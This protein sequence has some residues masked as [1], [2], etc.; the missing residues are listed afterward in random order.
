M[1][2]EN[3]NIELIKILKENFKNPFIALSAE[4]N[5]ITYNR[6]AANFFTIKEEDTNIFDFL[7]EDTSFELSSIMEEVLAGGKT[8]TKNII[9][10]LKNGKHAKTQVTISEF[11]QSFIFVTLKPEEHQLAINEI[12]KLK[13]KREEFS[14]LI[15]NQEI[16]KLI[17]TIKDLY[18]FTVLG[19]EKIR[20]E[21][22][23]LEEFLW[24]KNDEG[25]F[26]L[27]NNSL[28][29]NLGLRSVQ[30]EGK[31]E[32]ELLPEYLRE[33]YTS[34][35]NYIKKSHN[36]IVFEGIPGQGL[37]GAAGYQTIEIPLIDSEGN[38]SAII[39]IGQKTET[40]VLKH[41]IEGQNLLENLPISLATLNNEG[42]IKHSSKEFCKLF[43]DEF[44]DF[45]NLSYTNVF[46]LEISDR[47]KKFLGSNSESEEFQVR[48]SK[49]GEWKEREFNVHIK[50]NFGEGREQEGLSI[51]LEDISPYIEL[52]RIINT[53]GK[54]YEVL[55]QN[56]PEP[57]FIYDKE[58]LHFI[59]V[60]QAAL[61]LYGYRRDEFLK[62]DLTDLYTPEDI[63]T[64]LDSSTGGIKEGI[65]T[66]PYRHKRKNGESVYVEISKISFTYNNKDAHFNVIKD[67]TKYLEIERKNQLFKAAFDN[68]I[69]LIF[70][71]DSSGFIKSANIAAINILGIK[72]TELINSSFATLVKDEDRG[73]I[74]STIFNS[75]NR[76]TTSLKTYLKKE[77]GELLNVEIFAS[78]IFSYKNEIDSYVLILKSLEKEPIQE[79]LVKEIIVEKIV[80]KEAP[81]KIDPAF[82]SGIFHEIL[83]PINAM[84][85]FVQELA[86]SIEKMTPDQKEAKDFIDQNRRRLLS[87][88]NSVIEYSRLSQ[89][90]PKL[91]IKNV[92]ITEIV[93]ACQEDIS[94]I[95]KNKGIDFAYGKISS[96][97]NFKTDPL[98]F[99]SLI[100]LLFKI[101]SQF[102]STKK[103]YFS[104]Y[105]Q[106]DDNFLIAIQ[107]NYSSMSPSFSEN[108]NDIFNTNENLKDY[109]ISKL[110]ITLAKKLIDLLQGK[111]VE[112]SKKVAGF[113]FPIELIPEF[114]PKEIKSETGSE[115]GAK[116]IKSEVRAEEPIENLTSEGEEMIH[117]DEEEISET[118]LGEKEEGDKFTRHTAEKKISKKRTGAV[119]SKSHIDLSQLFCLYIEDQVDSQI[120]FKVQ[121]KELGD[122]KF[123]VSFEEALPLLDSSHF[124]FIVLDIN[125]QGEYNGLDALKIIH[126]M[127]GY[128]LIPIIAVTA[129]LLPGDR[130][131]FIAAGFNDF[132]SKPIFREKM[133]NSLEKIFYPA[134]S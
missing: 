108:F 73:L 96:S 117:E 17:E 65:F 83:T 94:D 49:K 81:I 116:E 97:L 71:T 128:E 86:E 114:K 129:Y 93:D 31:S 118:E 38:L 25:I 85:G 30:I 75:P 119:T 131:K 5:I 106:G 95:L 55:I 10:G 23:E 64:L 105:Q 13:I 61:T 67:I 28:A 33:V 110:S 58:N 72:E 46:P 84:L 91:E 35:V 125:L 63:Q 14:N 132:I 54:M 88:M 134:H 120:L 100:I 12:T 37:T 79:K 11:K 9:L 62:M 56:N 126:R 6:Q 74:N 43:S 99:N 34:L 45:R 111:F 19:K 18:P 22:D 2:K 123:A 47:I 90:E 69:N 124:D 42:I 107:D 15:K 52:E 59:D 109:G 98:K 3:I 36:L 39:G 130:E 51:F 26:I 121:L 7:A 1:A 53:R 115:K 66:G 60:N 82:L 4:G 101:A 40:E 92:T 48:L 57:I 112:K 102:T 41:S 104:A 80:E 76:G 20:K 133:V 24:I 21:I 77:K 70:T 78:P 27:V 16:K 127:P 103:I 113:L 8:I 50:R 89:E 44:T 32:K 122:I 87:T 29:K 68:A